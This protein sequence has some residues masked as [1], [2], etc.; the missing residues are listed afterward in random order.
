MKTIKYKYHKSYGN[1][2]EIHE[3]TVFIDDLRMIQ[4]QWGHLLA[5]IEY[6]GVVTLLE[7]DGVSVKK[8][9]VKKHTRREFNKLWYTDKDYR[10]KRPLDES[11]PVIH[12]GK[13]II[14][15]EIKDDDLS[16]EME[17]IYV[18]LVNRTDEYDDTY[19][20]IETVKERLKTETIYDILRRVNDGE[21]L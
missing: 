7:I 15:E 18:V 14:E 9:W 6:L 19:K 16:L 1:P 5:N 11:Q 4:N 20:Y 2:K 10:I 12:R 17:M 3:T 21:N 8:P 13:K